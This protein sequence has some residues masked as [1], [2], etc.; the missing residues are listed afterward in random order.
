MSKPTNWYAQRYV[1]R[2]SFAVIPIKPKSK[3]PVE[4]DW[5]NRA[6]TDPDKAAKH[7]EDN[8]TLNIG[9]ALGPSQMCSLDIDCMDSFRLIAEEFG[10]DL[11]AELSK[12][13]TIQGAD[14]GMRCMF[15]VPAQPGVMN[16]QKISWPGKGDP[17]G[18]IHK[19][20]MR[21]AAKAKAEGNTEREAELRANAKQFSAYTVL[22]LRV[23]NEGKQRYDVL[24]PSC[25]PDTLKPYRWTVQPPK[26]LAE[27]PEPPPWLMAIWNAWDSFKPQ[28]VDACPWI[29]KAAP[30]VP[31]APKQPAQQG[32]AITAFNDAH[33]LRLV[34]E[35]YGYTRKGKSR[36]LS[37]HSTTNLPGVVLFPDEDRCFIHHASDPLCSDDTGKPVNPFDLYVEYEHGGDVSKAVKAAAELL[38]LTRE[39]KEKPKLEPETTAP[40]QDEPGQDQG[41]PNMP[42]RCLGVDEGTY[43]YLPRSTQQVT[44]ISAAGH[45]NKSNLL[46][47]ARLEWWESYFSSKNGA[48]WT[49]GASHLFEVSAKVGTFDAGKVRGR[50]AWFDAGKSVLHL[51]DRLLVDGLE[52]QIP[53]FDTKF[54]YEKKPPL[55]GLMPEGHLDES[56]ALLLHKITGML[57]WG[58]PINSTLLA[59]WIVLAPICGAMNWRPHVWLTGQRG[60]GK[61][62]LVDN[63]IA[64][65]L[66][67]SSLTV[68][69]NSTEAGIRQRLKQDARPVIFDEAEGESQHARQRMQ[70]VLELARQASSDGVAEI[71]KGT[72]GG[73]ALSFKVRSMFMM[74]S[75]N[76]GLAQA[77]DKSRFT[78]LTLT[79]APQGIEGRKQFEGL[80]YFVNNTLSKEYCAGLRARTYHLIPV[81][82]KNAKVFA[83]AAAEHIGNQRA[84]DQLGALLAGTWSLGS[85][86]VVT[87]A[88]ALEYVSGQDWGM[89][90]DESM[91]SDETMLTHHILSSK[92]E[93]EIMGGMRRNR[94]IAEVLEKLS[95]RVTGSA[96]VSDFE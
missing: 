39:R 20:M 17:T 21:D 44:A 82:R 53:D 56:Q 32:S 43:Y 40:A 18:D 8:P 4:N 47:L 64:P 68:Q 74:G 87:D 45:S 96:E 75:I 12:V 77:A 81:I 16:Y 78:V 46:Q 63:I 86:E 6:F 58:K 67:D 54:I 93:I 59:G 61:T 80:E 85:S 72:A 48:D 30:Q 37:P 57:N 51:G 79:K 36:Y 1:E 41:K 13:P 27:W 19:Q 91:D 52:V 33:D 34:L 83:K 66:G 50:G 28:L 26:T 22:E 55:E 89:D 49:Q 60:T 10:I 24:P 9:L 3:L 42:F 23:S 15:R 94:T 92:L 62:W 7:W 5:G 31:K 11:D 35:Q 25:H 88:E 65:A 71:A 69:S 38:G 95:A 84:G 76:V 29:P 70:A 73:K 90:N 2:Y 14:K